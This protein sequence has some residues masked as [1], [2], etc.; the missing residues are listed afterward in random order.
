MFILGQYAN[1]YMSVLKMSPIVRKE[2][3][4]FDRVC[5]GESPV[6]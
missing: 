6:A 4:L 5:G 2:S 3:K 1:L